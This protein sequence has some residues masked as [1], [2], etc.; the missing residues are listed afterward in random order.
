MQ[1]LPVQAHTVVSQSPANKRNKNSILFVFIILYHDQSCMQTGQNSSIAGTT[2]GCNSMRF[3]F[4]YLCMFNIV[5]IFIV[6]VE[7]L[8][9]LFMKVIKD[10]NNS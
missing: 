7:A 1:L 10:T 6:S 9:R 5:A 8:A 2:M 3:M 4:L